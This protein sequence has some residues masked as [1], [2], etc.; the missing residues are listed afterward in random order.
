MQRW[1]PGLRFP[2]PVRIDLSS[3]EAIVNPH[4]ITMLASGFV[5]D[6]VPLLTQT[7]GDAEVV[8]DAEGK[9]QATDFL[10]E[11][12]S[13]TGRGYAL[14]ARAL[15]NARVERAFTVEV[16]QQRSGAAALEADPV[17]QLEALVGLR[18]HRRRRE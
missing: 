14:A 16:L 13:A 3:S 2:L 9:K 4:L 5:E 11:K 1:K 6:W 7:V 10:A 8:D 15:T 17:A 18:R 12:P